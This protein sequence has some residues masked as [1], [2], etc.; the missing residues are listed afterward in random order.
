[1]TQILLRD[2]NRVLSELKSHFDLVN[3]VKEADV[4]VLWQDI[5]ALELSIARTAKKLGKPIVVIQHGRHGMSDYLPPFHNQLLA[6]KVC[7]WSVYDKEQLISIGVNP[8]RIEITGT[9]VFK[10]LIGKEIHKGVNILFSPEHWDHDISENKEVMDKLKELCYKNNWN[11]KAKIMERH[12]PKYYSQYAVFSNREAPNHLDICAE[13]LGW[14]DILVSISEITFELM[15]Q[16]LNIPVIAY[17]NIK[18]RT[19]NGNTEQ[20]EYERPYSNAVKKIDNL[21]LLEETIKQQLANPNELQKERADITMTQGGIHI[22]D[23]LNNMI[24]V[25]EQCKK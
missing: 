24:K 6:D 10:H 12:N 22:E 13:T 14:A 11:L 20:L 3:T 19:F 21:V 5:I 1:M 4:V 17:T 2:H 25:I 8:K 23:P 15:A 9:T 7:V 18:Q 16:A